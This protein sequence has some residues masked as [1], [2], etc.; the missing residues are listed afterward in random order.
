MGR[1][2]GFTRE[3]V[4]KMN[5]NE[6]DEDELQNIVRQKLVGHDE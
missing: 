2:R 3:E 4:E 1:R 6:M 5:L